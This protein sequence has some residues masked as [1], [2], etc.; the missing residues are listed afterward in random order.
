MIK[1]DHTIIDS[2]RKG[3]RIAQT[4]VF[5]QL[6]SESMKVAMRYTSCESDAKDV[7]TKAYFKVFTKINT[8]KGNG[9]NFFGWVKRIIINQALDNLKANT[10]RMSFEPLEQMHEHQVKNDVGEHYDHENIIN[11]IQLLPPSAACVFNL[12]AM[13][14][15]SHKEIAQL[16]G[17]TPENSRYHLKVARM[18]LQEWIFKT[19]KS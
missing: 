12:Y 9:D 1:I 6:Y 2:C 14:G 4:K 8:F 11:L 13:E 17:I 16:I 19:E 10:F 3:E 7:L 18:K 15:Y 5:R